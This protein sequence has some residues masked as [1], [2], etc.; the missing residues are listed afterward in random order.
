MSMNER[1]AAALTVAC[2][3]T[4]TDWSKATML[5]VMQDLREYSA[6]Q[7]IEAL[8]RC[9]K[10]CK[11]RLSLAVILGFLD[12]GYPDANEAWA[13]VVDG[14]KCEDMTLCLPV[15]AQQ[16]VTSGVRTLW[17]SNDKYAA[18][19]SFVAQYER[20]KAN[21]VGKCAWVIELGTDKNHAAMVI[22]DAVRS[23]KVSRQ[24]AL[25]I[26]PTDSTDTRELLTNGKVITDE[27]R[28]IG[29]MNTKRILQ[30]LI[31]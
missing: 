23:G 19:Q 6:E 12:D 29:A 4:S 3:V 17:A 9:R 14:L 28:R 10:E 27:Q 1:I 13:M 31:K 20:L 15:I 8:N 25:S 24:A 22:E 26:L 16:A 7:V 11:G 21:T 18:R 2:E 5:A 30:K